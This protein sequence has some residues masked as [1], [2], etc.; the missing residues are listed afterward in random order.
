MDWYVWFFYYDKLSKIYSCFFLMSHQKSI[1]AGQAEMKLDSNYIRYFRHLNT[2]IRRYKLWVFSNQKFFK[3][4]FLWENL[5]QPK[6]GGKEK[7][8][9][10][11]KNFEGFAS[12]EIKLGFSPMLIPPVLKYQNIW[13]G[14]H[15]CNCD[16]TDRK[17]IIIFITKYSRK[18]TT[19]N[20][21][22]VFGLRSQLG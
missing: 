12:F 16:D 5:Q 8:D 20:K 3:R 4:L 21:L 18:T 2:L 15:Q 14:L 9:Y 6:R 17:E 10:A 7:K 22:R 13:K 1:L 19:K 11:C